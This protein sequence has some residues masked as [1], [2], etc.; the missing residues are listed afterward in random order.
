[1]GWEGL[2]IIESRKKTKKKKKNFFQN[3]CS[4]WHGW[5]WHDA[6]WTRTAFAFASASAFTCCFAGMCAQVH[7]YAQNRRLVQ[8]KG[9]LMLGIIIRELSNQQRC[10]RNRH[11]SIF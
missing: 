3:R 2:E 9:V 10:S 6:G 1:M 7:L 8:R 4:C 11:Y 5:M